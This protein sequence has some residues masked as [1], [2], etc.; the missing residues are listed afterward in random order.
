MKELATV[1]HHSGLHRPG[2]LVLRVMWDIW[3]GV[4][5]LVDAMRRVCPHHAAAVPVGNWLAKRVDSE[6]EIVSEVGRRT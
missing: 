2:T 5:E 4:E 6:R 1:T 3:N